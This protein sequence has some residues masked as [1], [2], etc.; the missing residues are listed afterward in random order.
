MTD[1]VIV[2]HK[3][4]DGANSTFV[5]SVTAQFDSLTAAH[6]AIVGFFTQS[7]F[8]GTITDSVTTDSQGNSY[9]L[10]DQA[11]TSISGGAQSIMAFA[12]P[13]IVGDSST[14][15][16]VTNGF[17]SGSEV[18]D[19]MAAYILEVGNVVASPL[20]GHNGQAQNALAPG[21]DNA[22]SGNITLSAAQVPAIIVGLCLNTSLVGA[23]PAPTPGTNMTGVPGTVWTFG[24]GGSTGCVAWRVV[25]SPGTYQAL[26]NQASSANEDMAT[27]A[28]ALLGV[29]GAALGGG[30]TSAS[31]AAGA[32]ST[33]IKLAGILAS[34]LTAGGALSGGIPAAL[35]GGA[36]SGLAASGA[37]S[38]AI[39][40]AAA[41]IDPT[42]ATADLGRLI[43]AATIASAGT[44]ALSTAIQLAGGAASPSTVVGTLGAVV[45]FA[46]AA[47][48]ATSAAAALT[49]W[50]TVTLAAPLN[51]G[52]GSI[53]DPHFWEDSAPTVGTV[54]FY[55]A[56]FITI[57]TDGSISSTSNN[58]RAVVQFFDGANWALGE[59]IIT[60]GLAVYADMASLATG[61]LTT[62]IRLLGA[63]NSLLS[64]AGTLNA[65]IKLSS[66]AQSV[67]AAVADLGTQI[68]LAAGV[69]D[70]SNASGALT[71]S[72]GSLSGAAVSSSSAS[73]FLNAQIQMAAAAADLVSAVGTLATHILFAA[74]AVTTTSTSATLITG[75]QMAGAAAIASAA[76][77]A[78]L[79]QIRV[80]GAAIELVSASGALTAQIKLLGAAVSSSAASG[81]L[82]TNTGL[83]AAAASI[84]SGSGALTAL[85]QM[86]AHAF[87]GLAAAGAL[88][89]GIPLAGSGSD[90]DSAAGALT[91]TGS[92]V[93]IYTEDPFF[94]IAHRRQYFTERFP[95]ISPADSVV[96]SFSCSDDLHG[97]EKLQGIAI[98]TVV[99]SAG[100]DDNAGGHV[101]GG[102]CAYDPTLELVEQPFHNGLPA[103]DYYFTVTAPTTNPFKTI[104]RYGLLSV[105]G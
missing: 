3:S 45:S 58:C 61:A 75:T 57:A 103:C 90:T 49:N 65:Q 99:A 80:A 32:L 91:A 43:A 86:S 78:L 95:E 7:D 31:S 34:S 76:T 11:N 79:T 23:H 52:L 87:S 64:A 30:S 8:A 59:V 105:R 98:V 16:T 44:G 71:G 37:L 29:A 94:V 73:A 6:N 47:S 5:H 69:L 27:C 40:F 70:D 10:T 28:V 62:A 74:S 46:A 12:A 21:T 38:T 35:A 55:D 33:A 84:S 97:T 36:I 63:A 81:S 92:A 51:T 53:L 25:T 102:I 101:L 20:V 2:Q 77:G 14:P 72:V 26:F 82:S 13:N 56:T 54:V 100:T 88:T 50:T 60:S 96:L 89:T 4:N 17:V 1:P 85:V 48:S 93:G 15:D 67:S 22:V 83:A 42:S 19:W 39:K 41:P 9:T 68:L 18:N 104:T 66:A 24:T